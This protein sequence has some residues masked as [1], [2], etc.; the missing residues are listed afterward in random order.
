VAMLE[1][2]NGWHRDTASRLLCERADLAAPPLLKQ[3]LAQSHSPLGRLHAMHVLAAIGALEVDSLQIALKDADEAVRAHAAKLSEAMLA[4]PDVPGSL[5]DSV[6]AMTDDASA[7]V[8]Y[9]LAFS[10]G[11]IPDDRK[12]ALLMAIARHH[13]GNPAVRAAIINSLSRFEAAACTAAIA[14]PGL[15]DSAGGRQLLK[16]LAEIVGARNNAAEIVQVGQLIMSPG[17]A[18][19]RVAA[20]GMARA[21]R[22]GQQ[23]AG[24]KPTAIGDLIEAARQL[25]AD[26]AADEAAR[27]EA[28]GLL[29][30][31]SFV[32]SGEELILLLGARQPQTVQSA[33][34]AALG[35]F[36]EP[37][38]AAAI[39][40]RF[41]QLSPRLRSEAVGIL[42]KRPQRAL[43]LLNGIHNGE[44]SPSD[45]TPIQANFLRHHK[46]ARVR[47]LADRLLGPAPAGRQEV[48][49][50][51]QS[52]LQLNGDAQRGKGVYEQRC[53][54]CHRLAGE[55]FAVGPDLTT[56]R[57]GG[58]EKMLVNIL[59]PNREVA[60]N[61]LTYVV[62]TKEGDSITGIIINETGGSL[63]V[64]QAFAKDTTVLRSELKKIEGQKLSLMP[65]GL[66]AGLQPQDLADLLEFV[67]TTP[68]NGP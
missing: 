3:L 56:V 33:V 59:D 42:L 8:Q 57:A 45:L 36:P 55:G 38:A 29:G 7:V 64:R 16:Q 28:V 14:E 48:V 62:E 21:L 30:T 65:E 35:R 43:A 61:F 4:K 53:I 34:I 1:H 68:A 63:T 67:S 15:R 31:T 25:A 10:A 27:F 17:T 6:R 24:N 23:R 13:A 52:A 40:K 54:S 9:Q 51:F 46:D 47:E 37:D 32:E 26:D 22:E 44:L 5:F 49:K 2:D 66:E 20:M 39:A 41:R 18:E 12:I 58:K 11:E 50:A 19:D 60:P